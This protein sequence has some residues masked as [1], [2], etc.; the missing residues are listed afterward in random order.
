MVRNKMKLCLITEHF[1]SRSETFI[2][3]HALGMAKRGHDV[4]VV[5]HGT[6]Q[7]IK[8]SEKQV[9]ITAGI[10]IVEAQSLTGCRLVRL[11][12]LAKWILFNPSRINYIFGSPPWVRSET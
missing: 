9:V 8:D 3:Q 12:K 11:L 7:G 2:V 10:S 6:G 1:P 4:S 5:C